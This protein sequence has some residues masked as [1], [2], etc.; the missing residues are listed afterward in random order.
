M[1]KTVQITTNQLQQIIKEGVAKLHKKTLIENRIKQINEELG[2]MYPKKINEIGFDQDGNPYGFDNDYS[3][4]AIIQ[5]DREHSDNP[6][7]YID[8]RVFS[9]IDEEDVSDNETQYHDL[10]EYYEEQPPEL[11]QIVDKYEKILSRHKN[12]E[13]INKFRDE[14]G[15]IGYTFDSGLDAE[16]YGLRPIGVELNQLKGWEDDYN[17]TESSRSFDNM[18]FLEENEEVASPEMINTINGYL[19]AA[20]WTEEDELGPSNIESD[21]SF[22]AKVDAYTDIK[23]FKQLA[24]ELIAQSG[25]DDEQIGHDLWLTR[26]GHGTGFWDRGL[27]EIGDKLADIA[28]GMGSKYAYVGDDGLIYID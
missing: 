6:D 12:Y 1:K 10:F 24:G 17:D 25:L 19:E 5:F 14:V 26:N 13:V 16:P 4:E 8:P 9:Q 15:K 22:E 2:A 20:L 28:R 27:G 23:K 18:D 7:E 11:K 21:V 3:E